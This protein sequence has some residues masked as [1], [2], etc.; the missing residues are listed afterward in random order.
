MEEGRN[1]PTHFIHS[2]INSIKNIDWLIV[3]L[4]WNWSWLFVERIGLIWAGF[5]KEVLWVM[6][7]TRPSSA[8]NQ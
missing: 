3:E 5:E 2:S 7:A 8:A 6:A 4:E 1:K